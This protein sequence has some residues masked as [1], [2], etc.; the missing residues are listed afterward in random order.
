MLPPASTSG[1]TLSAGPAPE[2][3]RRGSCSA[4]RDAGVRANA[5]QIPP[6]DAAL[7]SV[8]VALRERG[9]SDVVRD[10]AAG[11]RRLC[12]RRRANREIGNGKWTDRDRSAR[13]GRVVVE[14]HRTRKG[15]RVGRCGITVPKN[16]AAGAYVR[17]AAHRRAVAL[18]PGAGNHETRGTLVATSNRDAAA[19]AAGRVSAYHAVVDAAEGVYP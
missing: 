10:A 19:P 5:S 7:F 11:R 3:C 14:P 18:D 9:V 1:P 4:P 15:R 6:A 17:A 13:L 2:R 16:S 12:C 8:T